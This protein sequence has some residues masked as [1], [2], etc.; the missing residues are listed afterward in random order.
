MN[1]L[2]SFSPGRLA[3]LPLQLHPLTLLSPTRPPPPHHHTTYISH[4]RTH[5]PT[6]AAPQNGTVVSSQKAGCTALNPPASV[7]T[8]EE[9]DT[10]L[11]TRGEGKGVIIQGKA[12]RG[13]HVAR[14]GT[15]H[16]LAG[17]PFLPGGRNCYAAP[18]S[19]DSPNSGR[20]DQVACLRTALLRAANGRVWPTRLIGRAKSGKR[21]VYLRTR[22]AA[23]WRDISTREKAAKYLR[24]GG[25]TPSRYC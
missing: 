10:N 19:P 13:R 5:T 23:L 18:P 11:R 22:I 3:C 24:A 12:R 15:S 20:A 2:F 6:P 9:R 4:T 21:R 8:W 16:R 7:P 17:A 25:L 1:G 14:P